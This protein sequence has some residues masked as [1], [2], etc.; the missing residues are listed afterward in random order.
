MGADSHFAAQELYLGDVAYGSIADIP[1]HSAHVRLSPDSDHK[2][3]IGR[4]PLCAR[5]RHRSSPMGSHSR[6]PNQSLIPLK[7]G[8]PKLVLPGNNMRA[9]C[10]LDE[11]LIAF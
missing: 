9:W 4:S 1:G 5:R 7:T 8:L 11:E 10:C 6:S 2:A 3:D